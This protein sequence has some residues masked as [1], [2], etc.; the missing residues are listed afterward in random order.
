MNKLKSKI[1]VLGLLVAMLTCLFLL[2]G[3]G[4]ATLSEIYVGKEGLPKKVTYVEGQELDLTGGVLT[5]VKDD[6]TTASVPLTA[7]NVTVTGYDKSTLGKQSLTVTYNGKT[8]TFDVTVV[9]RFTAENFETNYF[10]GDEF[11]KSKGKIKIY[12]DNGT[13]F[14]MNINDVSVEILSFDS[15]KAGKSVVSVQC[16]ASDGN[17]YNGSFEVTVHEIA[18]LEF[19]A[20]TK[21]V[22]NSHESFDFK[23]GY[24]TVKAGGGSNFS[25]YVNFTESMITGFDPASV[26][27][28][29]LSTPVKQ[30]VIFNYAGK[31]FEFPIDVYYSGVYYIE[32]AIEALSVLDWTAETT[33]I[34][35][36]L[37][38]RALEALKQYYSL[39]VM[40]KGLID[41]EEFEIV[42]RPAAIYLHN[43]YLKEFERFSDV[44]VL[45]NSGFSISAKSYA[46]VEAARA[47]LSNPDDS[48]NVYAELLRDVY[49]DYSE[50]SYNETTKLSSKI[51]V[52]TEEYND[53]IITSFTY[54]LELYDMLK[55]IPNEWNNEILAQNAEAIEDTVTK[56]EN[57]GYAGHGNI[58]LYRLVSKWRE[59]NDLVEI[60]Y[61]YYMYVL[62]DGV[63]EVKS[64]LWKTVPLPG[65]LG[66]WYMATAQAATD[67][68]NIKKYKDSTAYL[69]DVSLFMIYYTRAVEL[70]AEVKADPNPL[71]NEIYTALGG[72]AVMERDLTGAEYGYLY[73]MTTVLD[74]EKISKLWDEYL[75]I[76]DVFMS[77][78]SV[79]TKEYGKDFQDVLAALTELS[80]AELYN[81]LSSLHFLYG[82]SRGTTLML[83]C[84]EGVRSYFTYVL[85]IY[86]STVT[87]ES[88]FEIFQKMLIAM[89]NYALIGQRANALEEFKTLMAEISADYENLSPADR[90]TFDTWYGNCYQK[91]MLIYNIETG[92]TTVA[93]GDYE[94][95]FNELKGLVDIFDEIFATIN[96]PDTADTRKN[97]L[98]PVLFAIYEKADSIRQEILSSN[99]QQLIE[100][101]G[102]LT[103]K[104]GELDLS[105]DRKLCEMR[106]IFV[107][108]LVHSY[109]TIDE[110]RYSAW[111][112]YSNSTLDSFIVESAYLII[113]GYKLAP[114]ANVGDVA[115]IM[116]HFRA[117]NEDDQYIFLILGFVNTYYAGIQTYY[118]GVYDNAEI[119]KALLEADI[120][121][122][123]YKTAAT[124]ENAAD[125]I[126]KFEAFKTLYDAL[127]D[128][129][130]FEAQFKDIYEAC[131][132][133]YNALVAEKNS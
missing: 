76:L 95:L 132:A 111:Y 21:K 42:V 91:Y 88:N 79:S 18:E 17:T 116:K 5:T 15:S 34:P 47:A 114:V 94:A 103:Y 96:D 124:E 44:F 70:S 131:L 120:S 41:D 36:A 75:E 54:M 113:Q 53:S 69:Y 101:F 90:T 119:V 39:S 27:E 117:L 20:P 11:D 82:S 4:E 55:V 45:T 125:F 56:I 59:N 84:R 74:S 13:S 106:K 57:S 61:S 97:E 8:T 3:C 66:E 100:A 51:F 93:L 115:E 65:V 108:Y 43:L 118:T 81:F 102:V 98:V 26:T 25:K 92:K 67:A 110:Q 24:F 130:A 46:A 121:Y 107:T 40:D 99:N 83:D 122:L 87:P 129:T 37:G 86:Y 49:D 127:A 60:I 2:S 73:H 123:V 9:A 109:R 33:E 48:F 30:T 89:E 104:F 1:V 80:P 52:H 7:D 133:Q 77:N 35:P 64:N 50:V 68:S 19:K 105:L 38:E 112:I 71:Y 128:K 31:M 22:Y 28:E 58:Q 10:V 63:E 72:D 32:S 62:E 85:A 23:G 16:N 12:R 78:A 126:A 6:G 29:N 14:Y